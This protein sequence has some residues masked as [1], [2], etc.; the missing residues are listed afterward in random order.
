MR[1]K[2]VKVKNKKHHRQD[3]E[4]N[5]Y[6]NIKPNLLKTRAAGCFYKMCR[7]KHL[8][9]KYID[10]KVRSNNKQSNRKTAAATKHRIN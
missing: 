4:N 3:K 7:T 6:K 8:E 10:I 2:I 5:I 9:P 1:M